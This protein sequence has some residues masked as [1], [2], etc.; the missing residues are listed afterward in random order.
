M[1]VDT[2]KSFTVYTNRHTSVVQRNLTGFADSGDFCCTACIV[3]LEMLMLKP[4]IWEEQTQRQWC[5]K[6]VLFIPRLT[7]YDL[8][9]HQNV[10]RIFTSLF[11]IFPKN[12]VTSSNRSKACVCAVFFFFFL[13]FFL[14]SW[15]SVWCVDLL[16]FT[17]LQVPASL[18]SYMCVGLLSMMLSL[19]VFLNP[20]LSQTPKQITTFINTGH[21]V[22]PDF[23]I[24][25]YH[26][27]YCGHL[28]HNG[29][30]TLLVSLV[31][32]GCYMR[33]WKH[34]SAKWLLSFK[35]GMFSLVMWTT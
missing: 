30:Y 33:A 4:Q 32:Q 24:H 5:K 17:V 15:V 23:S 21:L 14:K 11:C 1:D 18:C 22:R 10:K 35:L 26:S 3:G 25:V 29:L 6:W 2:Y 34:T 7:I 19:Y 16:F 31:R 13:F 9:H 8:D 12:H 28:H 20:C 27:Q